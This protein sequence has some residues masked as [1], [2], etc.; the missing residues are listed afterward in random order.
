MGKYSE[1]LIQYLFF[2]YYKSFILTIL[3]FILNMLFV[4]FFFIYL[5]L[6]KITDKYSNNYINFYSLISKNKYQNF[7]LFHLRELL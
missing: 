1:K 4:E 5:Y 7:S 3:D 6:K 2:I